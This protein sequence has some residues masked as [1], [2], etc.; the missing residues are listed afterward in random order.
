[1]TDSRDLAVLAA[2]AASSKQGADIVVLDVGELIAITDY[3]VIVSGSSDR[4]LKTIAEEVERAVK[5]RG[6]KPV[7]REGDAGARWLLIDYVDFV[8]HVFHEDEREFYRLENLWRDA[9]VVEWEEASA[10]AP[11]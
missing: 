11:G 1:V 7:R 6:V 8:V 4:Q 10:A 5:E 2:R 9:P 3:F